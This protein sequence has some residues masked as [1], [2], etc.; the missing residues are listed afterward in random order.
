MN[1]P[2]A[3]I[4]GFICYVANSPRSDGADCPAPAG[5]KLGVGLLATGLAHLHARNPARRNRHAAND[6]NSYDGCF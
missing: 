4:N 2:S 1:R 5:K 3:N 6:N